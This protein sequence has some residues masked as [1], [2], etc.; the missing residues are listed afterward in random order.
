M[1][2]TNTDNRIILTLDAGGTNF[3]FSAIQAN[4]EIVEPITFP[5]YSDDLDKCLNTVIEGFETVLNKLDNAANAISFAFPGPADYNNGII[6]D[7]PNFTAFKGGVPMRAMLE[8][9]FKLPVFINN[10]GNLYAYGE[11]LSGLLPETN[12]KLAAAGSIKVHKNLIGV[13]LGTGFGCGIVLDNT[14]LMGDNSCGAEIHNTLNKHNSNWNAEEN[15]STRAIQR[16]YAEKSG[17]EFN[18]KLMPKDIY[19]IAKETIK[20]DKEAALAAFD[21]YGENLGSSIAN[22]LTLIDGLVAIGGGITAAWD[23]FAPAMF[24]ELNRNYEN[25]RGEKSNR[26]SFGIYNLEDESS[27]M[28]YASGNVTE[29]K[30]P[31][32]G[33][34]IKY[35][36]SP[37]TAIGFSK[38][39]GSKAIALGA[40]AYA[41]QQ[42]DNH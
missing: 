14:L 18:N 33:R 31:N 20:G 32:S 3:V 12:K 24:K 8:N 25:F 10:D 17:T 27:F 40:Y 9:K 34:I 36:S 39:G 30:V 19:D 16:V 37:R 13:T 22:V 23:L 5:S 41:L 29:L 7:L 26:L 42:L 21:A 11:A 2:D 4:N 35:D 38:L 1:Y 6:G 15:V 28:E